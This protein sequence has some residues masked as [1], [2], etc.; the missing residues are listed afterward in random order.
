ML[1]SVIIVLC[2]V[3]DYHH[4]FVHQC[5][6][7]P[8]S[9]ICDNGVNYCLVVG[10][11]GTLGLDLE[12]TVVVLSV[13]HAKK[14]SLSVDLSFF[15]NSNWVDCHLAFR[16]SFENGSSPQGWQWSLS[17]LPSP[18]VLTPGQECHPSSIACRSL[19]T[20]TSI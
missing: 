5:V 2:I 13:V 12:V 7:L 11:M 17:S 20:S 8:A 10:P 4:G 16:R 18:C 9:V 19:T 3:A 14:N 6:A 1:P 15:S